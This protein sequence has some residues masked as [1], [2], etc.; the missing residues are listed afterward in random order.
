MSAPIL[1][2]LQID[3]AIA[4][5]AAAVADPRHRA[6]LTKSVSVLP[7][8]ARLAMAEGMIGSDG[9]GPACLAL[10]AALRNISGLGTRFSID[11]EL[12]GHGLQADAVGEEVDHALAT[13]A[14]CED[15]DL[16]V[17]QVFD[18]RIIATAFALALHEEHQETMMMRAAARRLVRLA[19]LSLE[20][21]AA[22]E[23]STGAI[24]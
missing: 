13:I 18:T 8:G 17:N 7:L 3:D 5:I 12:D 23:R 1:S 6:A 20:S 14:A 21:S 19:Y 4:V 2:S 10:G 22:A 24:D 11:A 16:D 9:A 15:N